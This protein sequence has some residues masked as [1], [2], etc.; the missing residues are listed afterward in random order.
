MQ[1]DQYY[2]QGAA[3]S[4]VVV[5]HPKT[6]PQFF[7]EQTQRQVRV[8]QREFELSDSRYKYKMIWSDD[9]L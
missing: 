1:A 9:D 6:L 4:D 5:V 2:R 3:E 8:K 7:E